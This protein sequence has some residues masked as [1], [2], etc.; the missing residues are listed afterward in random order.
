M[1]DSASATAAAVGVTVAVV[2]TLLVGGGVFFYL[3]RR[4][5]G[6]QA[7][8]TGNA[9]RRSQVLDRFHPAAKVTPFAG[10][11]ETPRFTHIPGEDMRVAR[12]RSDG[13]WEFSEPLSISPAPFAREMHFTSC[14]SPTSSIATTT[15]FSRKEK[16]YAGDYNRGYIEL[17]AEGLPPPAYSPREATQ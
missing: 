5:E 15:M 2:L 4:R 14:P 1:S 3:R 9:G 17:D 11:G 13:G 7:I 8:E 16:Q 6:V 10:D 12:R